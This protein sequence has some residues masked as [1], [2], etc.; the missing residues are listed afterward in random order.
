MG[1]II[2]SKKSEELSA[3]FEGAKFSAIIGKPVLFKK[4]GKT[5]YGICDSVEAGSATVK[6]CIPDPDSG[7]LIISDGTINVSP[8]E[9]SGIPAVTQSQKIRHFDADSQIEDFDAKSTE[10][11]DTEGRI[12]D[13]KDVSISGYAST[14][15]ATTASDRDGDYIVAGAFKDSLKQF[16]TNPIILM[17]HKNS[18]HQV[19]GSFRKVSEDSRGLAIDGRIS[20]APGLL[21]L[22]FKLVEKHIKTLSIGGLFLYME[23]GRGIVKI[24]LYE[25]SIVAVPANPDAIVQVRS[26]NLED[27]IKAFDAFHGKI[28][29]K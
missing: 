19:A 6:L 9:L 29:I 21:D 1:I 25:V 4:D 24:Y 8:E 27:A 7:I 26:L 14:F 2:H 28:K 15:Q 16:L 3:K 5:V 23:D 18:V 11:K 20:N 12:L 17:D 10:I 13:Y 22:R